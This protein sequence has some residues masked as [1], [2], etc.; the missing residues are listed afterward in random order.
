M[1]PGLSHQNPLDKHCFQKWEKAKEKR[2]LDSKK[3]DEAAVM[4]VRNALLL[5]MIAARSSQLLVALQDLLFFNKFTSEHMATRWS[6][7]VKGSQ[8][9]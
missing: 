8:P 2:K 9:V 5:L 6:E 1:S 3:D 4:L 7:A